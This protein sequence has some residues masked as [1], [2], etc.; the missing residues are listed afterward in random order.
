M[1]ANKFPEYLRDQAISDN[2]LDCS[3]SMNKDTRIDE[4]LRLILQ[5]I[6]T[7]YLSEYPQD[8][9]IE[10]FNFIKE[11]INIENSEYIQL[12]S[13]SENIIVNL[14]KVILKNKNILC[15]EP[16]FYR[17]RETARFC[18]TLTVF[19]P[20]PYWDIN[21]YQ[22]QIDQKECE[23]IWLS[24]PN[25]ITGVAIRNDSMEKFIEKNSDKLI[26]VDEA[27]VDFV[28][29]KEEISLV[30]KIGRYTNLVIL[31]SFSKIFGVPGIRCG[32]MLTSN[33]KLKNQY[34]ETSGTFPVSAISI[35]IVKQLYY[36][37]EQFKNLR[38]E[39][40]SVKKSI[41]KWAE[42]K[43]DIEVFKSLSN[44][45]FFKAPNIVNKFN[46]NGIIVMDFCGNAR[47]SLC[48][49]KRISGII[50]EKVCRILED[51]D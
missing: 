4:I 31:K 23:V 14:N 48:S 25:S 38:L 34:R 8:T 29:N 13:G 40:E 3:V 50:K 9:Y 46:E 41:L 15:C 11:K 17:I 30:E 26:I 20:G 39:I 27:G 47:L 2:C 51:Y 45:L 32:L 43:K 6:E 5:K 12:G 44:I 35:E 10:F 36:Q 49:D 19:A 18:K 42:K 1:N 7:S 16:N 28:N 21:E 37:E 24:N 22:D 33:L